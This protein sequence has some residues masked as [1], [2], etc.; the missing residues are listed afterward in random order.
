MRKSGATED[1]KE[2][3]V[4]LT[5]IAMR[6]QDYKDAEAATKEKA[7]RKAVSLESAGQTMRRLAMDTFD[8]ESSDASVL[9]V[10]N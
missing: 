4:L 9:R 8:S 7:K 1:Y 2:R 6:V 5:D 3:E 10:R